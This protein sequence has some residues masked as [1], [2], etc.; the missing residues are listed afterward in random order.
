MSDDF[1]TFTGTLDALWNRLESA[2]RNR[3]GPGRYLTLATRG[4]IDGAEARMVVLRRCD[5][6]SA[7]FAVHTHALS[8]KV[9]ELATDPAA[10][11]LLWDPRAGFQARLRV[12]ARTE[13]GLD[14]DWRR[15][16]PAG[17][18]LNY[19]N[20]PPAMPIPAPEAIAKATGDRAAFTRIT[21]EIERIDTLH[22]GGDLIRRARFFRETRFAGH[23]I[24]P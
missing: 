19:G 17:R 9:A 12:R 2:V 16:P 22:L 4:L 11:L 6:H 13:H 18:R 15:V 1:S 5:R 3:K 14:A 21:G 20:L 23:W 10:T 7:T 24:A 8:H